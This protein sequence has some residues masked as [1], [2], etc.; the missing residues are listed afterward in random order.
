MRKGVALIGSFWF[1]AAMGAAALGLL[2]LMVNSVSW[3]LPEQP[4]NL[5]YHYQ[6]LITG[7]LAVVAAFFAVRETRRQIE[8]QN[9]Q[10][11]DRRRRKSLAARA[12]LPG[13]LSDLCGYAQACAIRLVEI[14]DY[15]SKADLLYSKEKDP[16]V[17][18]VPESMLIFPHVPPDVIPILRDCVESADDPLAAEI[19]AL[20]AKLQIQSTRVQDVK[21]IAMKF[22]DDS[23][24]LLVI[25][26]DYYI[27]D[28]V[29]IF[30]RAG[31]FFAFARGE[32]YQEF[33][34][35]LQQMTTALMVA[36]IHDTEYPNLWKMIDRR[37]PSR[38]PVES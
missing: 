25:N 26:I 30:A 7:V 28:A 3:F 19:L 4:Q 34:P 24:E 31:N 1:G 2:S 32:R 13:A 29:E 6:T 16:P 38:P 10:E 33:T 12:A 5:L 11:E 20:T 8:Q 27:L 18:T 36:K 21:S 37:Y 14:R 23:C 15:R 9:D 17:V 35:S 22:H